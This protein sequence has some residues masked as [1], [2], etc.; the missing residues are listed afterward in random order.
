MVNNTESVLIKDAKLLFRN[1][2]GR[3]VP[4]N[5][6]GDRN[7]H[8]I[9]DPKTAAEL[10]ERNW[11]V[12][13]LKSREE[14]EEGEYHLKVNVNYKKGRP[15]R[16]VLVTSKGRTDLGADEV[17]II[18][19]ADIE[20]ADVFLNGWYSDMAGGGYSAF[21]KTIFVTLREDELELMYA[22]LPAS[23]VENETDREWA[24]VG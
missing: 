3:E 8:V 17:G 19:A 4:F 6:E 11:R 22:D 7:F 1:F 5:S 20:K 12:K 16:V 9:L 14:G 2:A 15:P 10:K 18:D 23:P 24:E 21:L 13:Q